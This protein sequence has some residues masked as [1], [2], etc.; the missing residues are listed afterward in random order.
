M[1]TKKNSFSSST[2]FQHFFVK[3]SWFGSLVSRIFEQKL[4]IPTTVQTVF[5]HAGQLSTLR[6]E[7]DSISTSILRQ[8]TCD[9][10]FFKNNWP[11][12][13]GVPGVF[14][15]AFCYCRVLFLQK[16]KI[17]SYFNEISMFSLGCAGTNLWQLSRMKLV[18]AQ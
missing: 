13:S 12:D 1:V 17:L 4:E 6:P 3:Y 18:A 14:Q 11:I 9:E 7:L 5:H 15:H 16:N 10:S 2:K 8:W